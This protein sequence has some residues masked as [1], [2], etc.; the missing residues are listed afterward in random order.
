MIYL[1][2]S[3]T[4]EICEASKEKM[5]QAFENFA[6]PSS[7]H[8]AGIKARESVESARE[9]VFKALGVRNTGSDR[10]I[11]TSCG[12]E[13][14]NTAIFG[15]VF[16]KKRKDG[17]RII[18]T[19]SEHPSVENA[20]KVL[21]KQG[22]EV[23]RLSTR[24]GV[25]DYE[26]FEHA[27][28]DRVILVTLMMVNNETGAYYD[29]G[30]FFSEAKRRNPDTVTHCDAVQGFLKCR[31]IPH[32]ICADLVSISA[33]KVHGPKGVGA[34]Y[35]SGDLIKR[36]LI[37]PYMHGG[38]QEGG[39]RSGT[40][41]TVGIAGFFGAVE[42]SHEHLDANIQK[43][44]ALRDLC[45]KLSELSGARVNK[46]EGEWAPHIVSIT[47]PDIKSETMLNFLSMK[48]I[49]VS[50]GSACSSHSK[51][52]SAS[53]LGFGLGEREADCTLRISLSENNTSEQIYEFAD[54]LKEGID[55]LVRIRK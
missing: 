30:R 46:P 48:D 16:S 4:T 5:R 34:L 55:R 8:S 50:A 29:V 22:F 2:N 31:F 23:I 25:L 38:G 26:Q 54:A 14:N 41:N 3:A 17:D 6:N 37:T 20:L 28:N 44:T 35:I 40:E 1:D 11:F 7:R 47:L 15:S 33:H 19:D 52:L 10:L 13:S 21:E 42:S 18:S 43:I 27:L 24:G 51:H 39:L 45:A 12:T 53:L 49:C 32:R 36:R 9:C